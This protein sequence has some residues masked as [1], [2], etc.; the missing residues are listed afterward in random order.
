MD[1]KGIF[2]WKG[3]AGVAAFLVFASI[4]GFLT[5]RAR[6]H[7]VDLAQTID[8]T[9]NGTAEQNGFPIARLRSDK[10]LAIPLITPDTVAD[11]T[12]LDVLVHFHFAN[13]SSTVKPQFVSIQGDDAVAFTWLS[14]TDL[15]INTGSYEPDSQSYVFLDGSE[16]AFQPGLDWQLSAA[17]QYLTLWDGAWLAL[18][19]IALAWFVMRRAIRAPS[20]KYETVLPQ[21]P[22]GMSPAEL[23][24]LHHGSLESD[25]FVAFIFHLAERGYMHIVQR[26][27]EV[28]FL[29]TS[30]RG[31][32][33]PYEEG[34]LSI[35]FPIENRPVYLSALVQSLKEELFSAAV[36]QLYVEVYAS[37]N[38]RQ[39]FAENPRSTHLRYKTTAILMQAFS[40]VMLVAAALGLHRLCP[41]L[42]P[43]GLGLYVAGFITYRYARRTVRYSANATQYVSEAAAFVGYLTVPRPIGPEGGRGELFYHFVPYALAVR[44]VPEWLARFDSL[45]LVVPSWFVVDEGALVDPA[46]F[47][48]RVGVIAN[49]LSKTFQ[50]IKDPNAD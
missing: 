8:I 37:F 21:P 29:R 43:I 10:V 35:L 23:A 25:D 14:D 19:C 5:Y 15:K 39:F 1:R 36:S 24:V 9:Q 20:W 38:G 48:E 31:G 6:L 44:S 49:V 13:A 7:P 33:T 26:E 45:A 18:V 46:D 27:Q 42:L 41:A 50:T 12:D 30:L 4:L 17:F 40:L 28:L 22:E 2:A 16:G 47:V 11:A 3:A 32:L 34:L